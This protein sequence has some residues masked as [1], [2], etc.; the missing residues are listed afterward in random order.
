[1]SAFGARPLRPPQSGRSNRHNGK[2]LKGPRLQLACPCP[3][4]AHNIHLDHLVQRRV[5]RSLGL[6]Q[7]CRRSGFPRRHCTLRRRHRRLTVVM[8]CGL[9]NAKCLSD[10]AICEMMF[11]PPAIHSVCDAR[12]STASCHPTSAARC[13]FIASAPSI[14]APSARK[15][16]PTAPPCTEN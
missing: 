15:G 14:S 8:V 2:R 11:Q 6:R 10:A 16:W 13:P 5:Q 4:G 3:A 12:G 9:H 1:M 7:P